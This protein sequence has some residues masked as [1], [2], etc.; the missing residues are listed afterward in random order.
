M[1]LKRLA[2]LRG[3]ADLGCSA[4]LAAAGCGAVR[5]KVVSR[6]DWIRTS[7]RSAPSRVRYQTAPR[8]EAGDG[9]RTRPRSLEGF[10]ATTTLR[11]RV[12]LR[13]YGGRV[14]GRRPTG[15]KSKPA[16]AVREV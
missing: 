2:E 4:M 10:C 3:D 15:A 12:R 9:N 8:P 11:P 5:I 7:D 13:H 1:G 6:G 16:F 14:R